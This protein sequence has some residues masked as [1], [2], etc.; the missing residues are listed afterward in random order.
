MDHIGSTAVPGLA[1]KD[2]IDIQVATTDL[3]AAVEL[4]GDLRD[5]GLVR[6]PGRWFDVGRDGA[7]HDKGMAVN[8]DP[9]RAVNLHVRPIETPTWRD[10]LLL[11]DWL[12]ATPSGAAEYA[13]LKRRLAREPHETI[14]DYADAKTPWLNQALAQGDEWAARSGWTP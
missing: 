5:A 3:P 4:A 8:A 7:E 14:D 10:A 13:A 6:P 2:V 1:A 9:G 12:R 11:R